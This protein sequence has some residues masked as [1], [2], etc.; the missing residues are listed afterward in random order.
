MFR[1]VRIDGYRGF[2]GYEMHDLGRVN[3]LVGRNNSGKT[4]VLEA[5]HVL[6]SGGDPIGLWRN[7]VRRGEIFR[8]Q[9]LPESRLEADVS[10]LF[11]G[12]DLTLNSRIVVTPDAN[13]SDG[14]AIRVDERKPRPRDTDFGIEAAEG[15]GPESALSLSIRG[16]RLGRSVNLSARGGLEFDLAEMFSQSTRIRERKLIRPVQFISTQGVSTADLVRLWDEAQLAGDESLVVAMLKAI[17]P[18]IGDIR[19]LA[20]AATAGPREGFVV[21]FANESRRLPLGSL[22]DGVWRILTLAVVLARCTGGMLLVDEIDT[23]LHHTVMSDMW[24]LLYAAAKRLN[25]QIFATTHSEDCVYSLASICSDD[26]NA[27]DVTIQRT[28]A[29]RAK[30]VAYSEAEIRA[31]AEHR[32]EVR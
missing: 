9:R 1:S 27:G 25:I 15:Q 23:G 26:E 21:R 5:L 14:L 28:D 13:E 11:Y 31:A 10:H 32:I 30:S 2:S 12:H 24:R 22:G 4:S 17:D 19:S 16:S 8:D 20:S 18:A 6:G 3:L 29:G 7:C